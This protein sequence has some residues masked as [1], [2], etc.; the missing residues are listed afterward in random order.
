MRSSHE[1]GGDEI[2]N[3]DDRIETDYFQETVTKISSIRLK[4]AKQ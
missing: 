2:Q 3:E 4:S 1:T